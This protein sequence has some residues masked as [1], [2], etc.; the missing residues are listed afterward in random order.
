MGRWFELVACFP[1]T[2]EG[3]KEANDYMTENTCTGVLVVADG[4]INLARMDDEGTTK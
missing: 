2:P 1:D 4:W 3:I